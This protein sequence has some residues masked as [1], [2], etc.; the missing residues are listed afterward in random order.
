MRSR[1]GPHRQRRGGVRGAR[2]GDAL[3]AAQHGKIRI[4]RATW[5]CCW[6]AD[7]MGRRW[8]DESEQSVGQWGSG[9]GRS[10]RLVMKSRR[11]RRAGRRLPH[12][13]ACRAEPDTVEVA[14][15]RAPRAAGHVRSDP[16]A[17]GDEQPLF[18]VREE[19]RVGT[20]ALHQVGAEVGRA[21]GPPLE[22]LRDDGE[23]DPR[24]RPPRRP[25][26]GRETWAG[27]SKDA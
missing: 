11:W 20:L 12:D 25:R 6:R 19:L 18:D 8:A 10:G 21:R 26:G 24:S 3:V 23:V 17:P 4:G 5:K 14:P 22:E 13:A 2:H 15:S 27:P 16:I 9:V 1:G 7:V